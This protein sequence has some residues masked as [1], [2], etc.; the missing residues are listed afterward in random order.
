MESRIR[1]LSAF[2]LLASAAA[3]CS[4]TALAQQAGIYGYG[5]QFNG[6]GSNALNSGVNTLYAFNNAGG[7]S[8]LPTGSTAFLTDGS[9]VVNSPETTPTAF[10]G[11]FYTNTTDSLTLRGASL[12]TFQNGGATAGPSVFLNYRV[13]AQGS[14]PP[15][16]PAGTALPNNATFS[17]G[18]N[19]NN[20][21]STESMNV[22]LLSSRP[23]GSYVVGTYGFSNS[24]AGNLFANNGSAN[25]GTAFTL[26]VRQ[27]WSA[28]GSVA[29]GAGTWNAGSNNWTTNGSTYGAWSAAGATDAAHFSGTAGTVTLGNNVSVNGLIFATAGYNISG[30]N[31]LTLSGPNPVINT[32]G[33]FATLGMD[34]NRL[35]FSGGTIWKVGT[36]TLFINNSQ[37]DTGGVVANTTWVVTGGTMNSST[38]QYNSA[39]GLADG[40]RLGNSSGNVLT[41]DGGQLQ[42]TINGGAGFASARTINVTSRGGSISDGGNRPGLATSGGFSINPSINIAAGAGLNLVS[43]NVLQLDP[44][45]AA[46]TVITGAGG[47]NVYGGSSYGSGTV[48][49][50]SN[51]NTYT[52]GTTVQQNATLVLGGQFSI[53]GANSSAV[54]SLAVSGAIDTTRLTGTAN[55]LTTSQLTSTGGTFNF[56]VGSSAS[57]SRIVSDTAAVTSGFTGIQLTPASGGSI[58]LGSY[59]LISSPN[60]GLNSGT[61]GF[62][63][64]QVLSIP[65]NSIIRN[66]GGTN[67]RLSLSTTANAVTLNVAAAP[68]RVVSIMP[69]GSSIAAGSSAQSPYNG[70]G[71]RAQLYQRLVNDGRFTPNFVGSDSL[72]QANNP[73]GVDYLTAVGQANHEGHPGYRTDE[74]LNNLNAN[75]GRSGNNG[76]FWLAPGNGRNPDYVPLYVGGNDFVPSQGGSF[77]NAGAINNLNSIVNSIA[78]L[79]PDATVVVSS[80]LHRT[81]NSGQTSVGVQTYYNPLI[82]DLVYAQTLAGRR[83]IFVDMYSKITPGNSLSL[84]SSDGIHPTQTGYNLMAEAWYTAITAGQAFYNGGVNGTWASSS[85]TQ[86]FARTNPSGAAPTSD[87]D[88]Y[89]NGGGA[90]NTLGGNISVRGVNFTA[91]QSTPVTINGGGNTLTL[92]A[93]GVTVQAGTGAHVIASDVALGANQ[94]WSN[95]S[96]NA[97]NVSGSVSGSSALRIGATGSFAVPST[98]VIRLTGANT[99]SGGT[100][101]NGGML[102]VDNL[103]GSGTGTGPVTV[104]SL[105]TLAGSGSIAGLALNFGTVAPSSFSGSASRLT[106][107]S[108]LTNNG[109]IQ[110]KLF[111]QTS[112]D[113]LSAT[114]LDVTAGTIAVSFAPSATYSAGATWDLLDWSTKTGTLSTT[115]VFL[116]TLTS[117]LQWD[118]S[119]LNSSGI[120]SVSVIPEVGTAVGVLLLSCRLLLRRQTQL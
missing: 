100:T 118:T 18:G 41:L 28:N 65:A 25:Y 108:Q 79:R 112:S 16:F 110:L 80:I 46:T 66:I 49:I 105:G 32:S 102:V 120:V 60:G 44:N 73:S 81:D 58:A 36:G 85:W 56:Q 62:A 52:G 23:A 24:S 12:L 38:G 2:A 115:N 19:T 43:T 103:T 22:N 53:G 21:W 45:T 99:Y 35:A 64:S 93:G 97:F 48:R 111:G 114:T 8:L 34:A 78:T 75:S 63:G 40:T 87:T 13:F 6:T 116:P 77:T 54:G 57:T 104:N 3:A 29:G 11:A 88:V 68:T 82:P 5:L 84:I 113:S 27:T 83:V 30:S 59:T 55:V 96:T 117:G 109:A 90:S 69:L 15:S 95:V 86:D 37:N 4:S 106:F 50:L 17:G 98:G 76:G 20:R 89:F 14:T 7:S 74:I 26:G 33:G 119:L 9:R 72:T 47:I 70:G 71:F 42:F 91:A 10:L 67:Y 101:I 51:N 39:I 94:T 92:G 107:T 1:Q 61:V 31:T